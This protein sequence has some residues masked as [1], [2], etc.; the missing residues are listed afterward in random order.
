M[1]GMSES[2]ETF[3][4]EN[5]EGPLDLL[6]HLIN[7]QEID[8]YQISILD[9]TKQYLSRNQEFNSILDRGAEFISLAAALVWFKSKALLPKH[10]QQEEQNQEEELDPQFDIIH[11][12]VDYC[13]FKQ[14]AKD[15]SE[16]EQQQGAYCHRGIENAD[17]K[18]KLGIDHL[19]L[20]DLASLF[21]QI[22]AKAAPRKGTIHEEE[23][24]VSDKI[25]HLRNWLNKQKKL[26]FTTVFNS[27]LSRIE[28][29]VTFLALLEMMKSGQA[30]VSLDQERK[31]IYIFAATFNNDKGV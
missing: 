1:V 21:Q 2:T 12:L 11:Q 23:W 31:T 18:K 15:L 17:I 14:A 25:D 4:L 8:I 24:K 26:D 9:I 19:S 30:R 7:R 13:R 22:L 28:L 5:F 27:D 10:E 29:I 20:D 16:R 6:W 3:I